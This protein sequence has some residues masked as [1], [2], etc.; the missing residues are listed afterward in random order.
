MNHQNGTP[1]L[2]QHIRT[3]LAKYKE[4]DHLTCLECGYSGM[5][6]IAS[7]VPKTKWPK[8]FFYIGVAAT[9]IFLIDFSLESKGEPILPW[10]WSLVVIAVVLLFTRG[11]IKTYE[12]P[13]CGSA[14]KQK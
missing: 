8:E 12:C 4:H 2:P 14:L 13:N 7:K 3:S 1:L 10:W 6:G 11:D 9:P 5:M